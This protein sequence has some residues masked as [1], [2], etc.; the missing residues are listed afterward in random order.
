[1]NILFVNNFRGRG[2]GEEFLRD[3]LP[4][5]VAKGVQ[6][7]LVCQ[8]NAP[9]VDMFKETDIELHPIPRSGKEGLSSVFKT[10]KVIR[11]KRYDIVAISRG[12][13]IIQSWIGAKLSGTKPYLIYIPQVPEFISSRFLLSRMHKIVTISRYIRDKI[14]AFDPVKSP[15]VGII[16]YGIDLEKFKPSALHSNALRLRFG[17][18]SKGRVIGTV[19]D[20]WK[21]QIEFLDALVEIK[22]THA[23]IKFALVASE[24]GIGQIQEFKDRAAALGLTD[25]II[26]MG[27]LSKNEMLS[28][29]AN[30]DIAVS[31]HRHEGFG[32][33]ILEALA[34]GCP[35]VAF[36]E[37][38]VR[39]S[40][41]HCPGGA[42]VN[43]GAREMASAITSILSNEELR[44]R[45]SSAG[46]RWVT[47]RFS[48]E[49]M[50]ADY[51][52]FFKNLA[53]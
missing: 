35:V 19:G 52:L 38:G 9:L 11:D 16:Y 20:L 29:Y 23:D 51:Y 24:T 39:D 5:L 30:I 42:L 7:G 15:D 41:E 31:S 49:R 14:I 33:W 2:G 18:S 6:V 50:V 37:G 32:I 13:D 53:A 4:G 27:R 28:F 22:Q 8:P 48:R 45:M 25:D 26:W 17:L 3:L 44:R 36:N 12:H 40:L 21:N 46:L 43:G 47:E 1:M 34:M 10:A